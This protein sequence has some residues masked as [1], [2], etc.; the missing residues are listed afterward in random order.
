MVVKGIDFVCMHVNMVLPSTGM[1]HLHLATL[2]K[3]YFC[4]VCLWKSIGK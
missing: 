1:Q 3:L 2:H 4:F